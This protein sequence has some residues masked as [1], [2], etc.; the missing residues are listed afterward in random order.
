M[1]HETPDSIAPRIVAL[2]GG[3]SV[4]WTGNEILSRI[5]SGDTPCE[6]H[7][8]E[9]IRRLVRERKLTSDSDPFAPTLTSTTRCRL[10]YMLVPE[11][12]TPS[13]VQ[14][15]PAPKPPTAA[16]PPPPPPPLPPS[17]PLLPSPAVRLEAIGRVRD[18]KARVEREWS[19]R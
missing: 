11:A 7:F 10:A 4:A 1:C 12:K 15:V 19:E 3:E 5:A 14:P 9:T 6:L 18:E 2:L 16:V 8:D 17:A 13:I